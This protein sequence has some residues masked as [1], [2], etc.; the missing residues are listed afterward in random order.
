MLRVCRLTRDPHHSTSQ[1][2]DLLRQRTGRWGQ[3][4][5]LHLCLRPLFLEGSPWARSFDQVGS[6][7][8]FRAD[9]LNR[10]V[11]YRF[12]ALCC[13]DPSVSAWL[14]PCAAS[15]RSGPAMPTAAAQERVHGHYVPIFEVL[16]AGDLSAG[17]CPLRPP[18]QAA[19]TQHS[20]RR[21]VNAKSLSRQ[22]CS[23]LPG[24]WRAAQPEAGG[25]RASWPV[26]GMQ[27]CT[28]MHL[29]QVPVLD[30]NLC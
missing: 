30:D 2:P 27:P 17:S 15:L 14:W 20:K 12:Q 5:E 7:T 19:P 18:R 13:Q 8:S 24:P 21:Q 25:C 4:H 3:S 29:M 10:G 9:T 22:R 23:E 16:Q 11:T 1:V 26:R 28:G 6:A